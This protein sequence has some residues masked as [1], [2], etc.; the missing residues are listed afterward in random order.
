[1]A[2][3]GLYIHRSS[4]IENIPTLHLMRRR[5]YL[6]L[7]LVFTGCIIFPATVL[8]DPT[9]QKS[10]GAS[11]GSSASS[12]GGGSSDI[13]AANNQIGYQSISTSVSYTETGNGVQ[14]TAG[15][16]DTET[17]AISGSAYYFSAM[18]DVLLGND[19]FRA[20]YDMSIGYTNYIGASLNLP[21]GPTGVYGSLV[22]TSS[23]VLKNI[24]ARYGKGFAYRGNAMLTPYFEIGV[25]TWDRGVNGGERYSHNYYAYGLLTQYSL[26][27]KLVLSVDAMGGHTN[28][29]AIAVTSTTQITGFT[30]AL[31]DSE[32]YKIGVALDYALG[33]KLHVNAGVDYTAFVYGISA[34]Q[35]SGLLEPDSNTNYITVRFGLGWGF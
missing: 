33:A 3:T 7:L 24:T 26:G 22:G 27:N 29:S 10:S 5:N 18:N 12:A 28:G 30:T 2:A 14:T 11:S 6:R 16:L 1:M 15:T 4:Y 32:L 8:A 34:T 9:A 25:H 21:N 19:Y 23:A 20:T 13:K 35:P 17:G 31:G